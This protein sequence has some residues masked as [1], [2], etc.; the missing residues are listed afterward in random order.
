MGRWMLRF[1]KGRLTCVHFKHGMG[2]LAG[3]SQGQGRG[4]C[5]SERGGCCGY[6]MGWGVWRRSHSAGDGGGCSVSGLLLVYI[7][8]ANI[9]ESAWISRSKKHTFDLLAFR[10]IISERW[11]S[12]NYTGVGEWTETRYRA[13]PAWCPSWTAASM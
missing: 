7:G 1:S 4:C 12:A 5:G 10:T 9:P 2:R 6:S 3:E 8:G 13:Y 11:V